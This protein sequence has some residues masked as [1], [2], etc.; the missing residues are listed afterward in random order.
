M[1]LGEV[2]F[3]PETPGSEW[4]CWVTA[5]LSNPGTHL[6]TVRCCP[7][8]DRAVTHRIPWH[9]VGPDTA[10]S[11]Q[12]GNR[13]HGGLGFLMGR[14]GIPP[15]SSHVTSPRVTQKCPYTPQGL[16][17]GHSLCPACPTRGPQSHRNVLTH[18]GPPPSD[19]VSHILQ[20][21]V[22]GARVLGSRLQYP[23]TEGTPSFSALL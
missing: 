12:I 1:T 15:T 18:L 23:R 3:L 13:C 21:S 2:I 4:G 11:P 22:P 14:V 8:N 9:R 7:A 17:T 5:E 10:V 19:N 16:C 20:G 6:G